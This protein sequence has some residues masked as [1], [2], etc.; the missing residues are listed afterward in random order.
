MRIKSLA[1]LLNARLSR[2]GFRIAR[3]QK[4]PNA[5]VTA[6]YSL[7]SALGRPLKVIVIGANDG[8]W[9]DPLYE[10]LRLASNRPT[11]LYCEPQQELITHL[12]QNVSALA[13]AVFDVCAISSNDGTFSLFRVKPA[14][15]DLMSPTYLREAPTYRAPSG[16]ASNDRNRVVSF[17]RT[18]SHTDPDE[19]IEEIA[20]PAYTIATLLSKHPQFSNPDV[21]QIDI[22]G[23]DAV[24]VMSA[25]AVIQPNLVYYESSGLSQDELTTVRSLARSHGY[26]CFAM[27]RD[28]LLISGRAARIC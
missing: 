16:I 28:D 9:S 12:N 22:E 2:W 4:S 27:D 24:V 5:Y 1:V 18:H 26:N 3:V 10:W 20:V 19:A 6:L 13:E 14:S 15:W 21:L 23:H 8:K 7:E 11:I 25:L 17:V